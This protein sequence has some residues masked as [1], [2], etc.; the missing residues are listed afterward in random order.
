M[1][2]SRYRSSSK[3]SLYPEKAQKSAVLLFLGTVLQ[4]CAN[5]SGCPEPCNGSCYVRAQHLHVMELAGTGQWLP[6]SSSRLM[7]E[8]PEIGK[9]SFSLM[10]NFSEVGKFSTCKNNGVHSIRVVRSSGNKQHAT[11]SSYTS[12]AYCIWCLRIVVYG[13]YAV[14]HSTTCRLHV[15]YSRKIVQPW[16]CGSHYSIRLQI[17]RFLTVCVQCTAGISPC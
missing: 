12:T 17:Q 4:K 5:N 10:G 16:H 11:R 14:W 15:L 6:A 1:N 7:P 3:L 13:I 8:L 2:G 9:I